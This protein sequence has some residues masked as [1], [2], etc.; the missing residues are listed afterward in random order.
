MW[1][2]WQHFFGQSYERIRP[3][4]LNPAGVMQP[5]VECSL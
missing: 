2:I 5:S 1:L 3:A 4:S